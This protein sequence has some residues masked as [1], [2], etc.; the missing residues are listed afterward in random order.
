M[1]NVWAKKDGIIQSEL[2]KKKEN[3]KKYAIFTI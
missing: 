2:L 1:K 3:N